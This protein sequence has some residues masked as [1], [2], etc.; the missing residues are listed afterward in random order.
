MKRKGLFLCLVLFMALLPLILVSATGSFDLP[1][2]SVDG[3]GGLSSGSVFELRGA[4]GQPDAGAMQGGDYS[5]A[6]GFWGGAVIVIP[7]QLQIFLPLV[8]R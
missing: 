6:G 3:G 1:W 5:L 2:W 7:P 4:A 8:T